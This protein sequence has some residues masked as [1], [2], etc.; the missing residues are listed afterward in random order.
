MSR[1]SSEMIARTI[2]R[3]E[4]RLPS[5]DAS[6]RAVCCALLGAVAVACDTP[7]KIPDYS[8]TWPEPIETAAAA[9]GSIYHTG[10]DVPLFENSVAHRVGDTLTI[11]LVESTNASKTSSTSTKK[12]T[13]LDLAAPNILGNPVTIKGNPLSASMDHKSTFDGSGDTSQSNSLNGQ[14]TVTVAKRLSNG[15]LLV[16]GQKWLTLSQGSEFVRVQGIV[17]PADIDPDNNVPSSKI[18]D[19]MISYGGQGALADANSPGLLSRFF[20]SKWLPF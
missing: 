6:R 19:A 9:T 10:H 12:A 4:A 11:V 2:E 17:R 20:N 14:I 3:I 18:A 16:R 7:P 1:F 5:R 8:A 13:S 15:N